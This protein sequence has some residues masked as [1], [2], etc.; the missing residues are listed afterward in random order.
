MF[1]SRAGG[2][3]RFSAPG[4][5]HPAALRARQE[6]QRY[7]EGHLPLGVKSVPTA[8]A[9]EGADQQEEKEA[10]LTEEEARQREAFPSYPWDRI[11]GP[12]FRVEL[13]K[14][15]KLL[16]VARRDNKRDGINT[17]MINGTHLL[18]AVT[19]PLVVVRGLTH[20]H[21]KLHLV[22]LARGGRA[23]GCSA[24]VGRARVYVWL[25]AGWRAGSRHGTA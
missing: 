6:L 13:P 14:E 19:H 15:P 22:V 16:G 1:A 4:W 10:P 25:R 23:C 24:R 8:V 18:A 12:R 7:Q 3:W 5:P 20:L 21:G 17:T 2:L 9:E 11:P